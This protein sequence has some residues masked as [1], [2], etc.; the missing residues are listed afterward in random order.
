M[1]RYYYISDIINISLRYYYHI[2]G[3]LLYHIGIIFIS[4]MLLPYH[5]G[6]IVSHRYY[7]HITQYYYHPI[8]ISFCL[9]FIKFFD[10]CFSPQMVARFE[11]T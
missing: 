2:S 7:D 10:F 9:I 4:Q 8:C 1:H 11:T 3:M 6:I 5:V